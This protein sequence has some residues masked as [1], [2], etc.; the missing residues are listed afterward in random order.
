MKNKDLGEERLFYKG[1]SDIARLKK[2]YLNRSLKDKLIINA[3]I[4]I[5][6]IS[7]RVI[8]YGKITKADVDGLGT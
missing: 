2:R 6:R 8:S 3:K 1:W 5:K 7:G 4:L